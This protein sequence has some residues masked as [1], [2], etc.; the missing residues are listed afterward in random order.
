M[1]N[2]I[3]NKVVEGS[4]TSR[5]IFCDADTIIISKV[6]EESSA[7]YLLLLSNGGRYFLW[8][9]YACFDIVSQKLFAF[10]HHA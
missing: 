5:L 10:S 6:I 8:F 1:F 7:S 4:S 2:S 9:S 3:R